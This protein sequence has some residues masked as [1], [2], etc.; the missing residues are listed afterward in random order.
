MG[1]LKIFAKL[2]GKHLC[3]SHFIKKETLAQV[4]SCEFCEIFK[5][6][7]FLREPPVA[8]SASFPSKPKRQRRYI[9]SRI[10]SVLL[11]APDMELY[12]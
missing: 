10:L 4:P 1:I 5:S 11:K 9:A 12:P 2:L 8:V 7:C 3:Q 6:A